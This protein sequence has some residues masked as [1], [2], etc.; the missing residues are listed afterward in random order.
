MTYL[1]QFLFPRQQIFEHRG[2]FMGRIRTCD[3][4]PPER[5]RSHY[6]AIL[7]LL[8]ARGLRG[9]LGSELYAEPIKYGRSP[10]N[11]ISELRRNGFSIVGKAH[12]ASDW[13]Y[14]LIE[15]PE[16]ISDSS[17][18]YE[19]ANGKRPADPA[20]PDFGPLFRGTR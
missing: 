5:T 8:R 6:A 19:R 9:V 14:T 10:R 18:W 7:A 17:D 4:M 3:S 12:G 1:A 11:R 13:H 20:A 2:V 16:A 15:N